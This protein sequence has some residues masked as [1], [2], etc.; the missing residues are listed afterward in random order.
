MPIRL[1]ARAADFAERFRAFL[2]T[3][4]EVAA[5]VEAAVRAII[6]DV[7]ARDQTTWL[8]AESGKVG[9][10]EVLSLL[11]RSYPGHSLLTQDLGTVHGVDDC[12]CGRLGT[13]FSV[14]GRVPKAE[15]RGCS[16][17]QVRL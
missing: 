16:D 13:R 7:I 17:T 9:V 11:P 8:P 14:A 12:P 1:D 4:R 5:D 6:A 10:L 15:I 3:K 2:A